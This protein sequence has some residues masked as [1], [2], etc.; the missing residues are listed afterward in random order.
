[1]ASGALILWLADILSAYAI[2]FIGRLAIA[3]ILP[4]FQPT[5]GRLKCMI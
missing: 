5:N 1:M 3:A 2:D 4:T